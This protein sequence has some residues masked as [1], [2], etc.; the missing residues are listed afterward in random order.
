MDFILEAS[1]LNTFYGRSHILFNIDLNVAAGE[2]VCL[3]GRN[4]AG[5]TTTFRSL[6][7]LTFPSSGKVVIKGKDCTR[8]PPFK[9]AKIGL[10]LVP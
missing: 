5:K 10:G 8:M 4:G 7:G 2:T 6:M 9:K 1:A 3:M